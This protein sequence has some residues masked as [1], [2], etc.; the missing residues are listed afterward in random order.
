[1]VITT[2]RLCALELV[3]SFICYPTVSAKK[4]V[5]D[6]VDDNIADDFASVDVSTGIISEL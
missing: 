1:M 2:L 6:I 3:C 4:N 5:G